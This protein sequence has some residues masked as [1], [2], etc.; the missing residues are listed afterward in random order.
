MYVCLSPA[1]T[2]DAVSRVDRRR[3]DSILQP[4]FG[5]AEAEPCCRL[6]RVVLG[7]LMLHIVM[8]GSL[9]TILE[10]VEVGGKKIWGEM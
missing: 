8:R 3:D 7:I 6:Y 10:I 5:V 9:E 2:H 4:R 1:R